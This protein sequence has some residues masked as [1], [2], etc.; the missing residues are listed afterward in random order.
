MQKRDADRNR[1]ASQ[2]ASD[3]ARDY[4]RTAPADGYGDGGGTVILRTAPVRESERLQQRARSYIAPNAAPTRR[5]C[6]SNVSSQIGVIGEGPG[7]TRGNVLERGTSSVDAQG[8][9]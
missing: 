4:L 6:S 8:C 3:D 9:R 2:D 1:E 5:D 7:A